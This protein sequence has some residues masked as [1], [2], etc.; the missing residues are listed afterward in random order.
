MQAELKPCPFCGGEAEIE[1]AG[2]RA[3]SMIIA[4]TECGGR[5]ESGDEVGRTDPRH[6]NWNMRS[7]PTPADCAKLEVLRDAVNDLMA[8][9]YYAA[10]DG[11][12]YCDS[13]HISRQVILTGLGHK[14]GCSVGDVEQALAALDAP[15][16]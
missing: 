4:C 9:Q 3:V 15:K 1:R 16:E 12:L 6:W 13:C 2:T 7:L 14:P 10:N 5:M 11:E 8:E